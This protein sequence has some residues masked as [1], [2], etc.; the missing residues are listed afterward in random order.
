MEAIEAAQWTEVSLVTEL[1]FNRDT[2]YLQ[3]EVVKVIPVEA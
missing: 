3:L 2:K 1:R